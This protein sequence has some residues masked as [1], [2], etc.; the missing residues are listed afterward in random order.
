MSLSLCLWQFLEFSRLSLEKSLQA[1]T[2]TPTPSPQERAKNSLSEKP[3]G[4]VLATLGGIAGGPLGLIAAPL[5]LL[6]LTK[7]LK[8]T[9]EKKANRF[10]AWALSGMLIAPICWFPIYS[11]GIKMTEEELAKCNGGDIES[12]QELPEAWH[13][14]ITNSEFKEILEEEKESA[15]VANENENQKREEEKESARVANE[16]ERKNREEES[17]AARA[18]KE[19]ERQL[20]N[21]WD[22]PKN[23]LELEESMKEKSTYALTGAARPIQSASCAASSN[24]NFWV[25]EVRELGDPAPQKMNVE[26]S[27]STGKW[28]ATPISADW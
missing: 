23:K 12:C 26:F 9:S 14:K 22:S 18:V 24:E 1:M 11:L 20:A 5:N 21:R 3:I 28:A 16:N 4:Y 7:I 10:R 2:Q 13:E 8:N 15:R 25:C 27:P 17:E 19:R 6:L